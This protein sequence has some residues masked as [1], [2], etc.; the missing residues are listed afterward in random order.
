MTDLTRAQLI[1]WAKDQVHMSYY[2]VSHE[3][4]RY[5]SAIVSMLEDDAEAQK[6]AEALATKLELAALRE[7]PAWLRGEA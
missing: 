7:V 3:D 4:E 5:L 1:N 2:P 6:S